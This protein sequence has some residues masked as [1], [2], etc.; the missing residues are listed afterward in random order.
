ML[1]KNIG[2][3]IYFNLICCSGVTA[4]FEGYVLFH[5]KDYKHS[6]AGTWWRTMKN[7]NNDNDNNS[8]K[9]TK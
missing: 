5:S 9:Y 7:D 1:V 2:I 6:C 8:T 4:K 3:L